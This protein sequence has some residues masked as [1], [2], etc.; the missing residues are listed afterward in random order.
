MPYQY[1]TRTVPRQIQAPAATGERNEPP[2]PQNLS[3]G[4]SNIR[5][6]QF[7]AI[8]VF[9]SE[10]H[11]KTAEKDKFLLNSLFSIFD[12]E[13]VRDTSVG[14]YK[15]PDDFSIVSDF[16][17]VDP[18]GLSA[19]KL[20][21][22]I[23]RVGER[24]QRGD[25]VFLWVETEGR[26]TDEGRRKLYLGAH[27]DE[28]DRGDLLESIQFKDRAGRRRTRLSILITDACSV[29]PGG[30]RNDSGVATQIWKSLYF[31]HEGIVD[32]SSSRDD[33]EAIGGEE[34][35]FAR[36]FRDLFDSD[37]F[38]KDLIDR[39]LIFNGGSARDGDGFIDWTQEFFPLLQEVCR[40][41]SGGRQEP[42]LLEGTNVHPIPF[43]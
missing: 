4:R 18:V 22:E 28:M 7:H 11:K 40:A 32:I 16:V 1:V 8:L 34:S 37:K 15:V 41:R 10:Q 13:F 33:Q 17:V 24:V 20:R 25:V 12:L 30:G 35:L 31:G 27:S 19:D 36:A 6:A 5:F 43:P 21:T 39:V 9:D 23:A 2:T 42:V 3:S 26:I 38:P 14:P 29:G